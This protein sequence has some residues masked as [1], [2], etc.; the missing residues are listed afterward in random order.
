MKAQRNRK[1][2]FLSSSMRNRPLTV[3]MDK[4]TNGRV[5]QTQG[6]SLNLK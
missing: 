4:H 1:L 2:N 6:N 5:K 3:H